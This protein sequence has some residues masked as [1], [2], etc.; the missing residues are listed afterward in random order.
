M[1]D[2]TPEGFEDAS[3]GG[4]RA[5]RADELRSLAQ[6]RIRNLPAGGTL[7]PTA[8]IHEAYLKLIAGG[9][10]GWDSPAHFFGAAARA[11]RNVAVDQARRRSRLKRGGAGQRLELDEALIPLRGQSE[12]EDVLALNDALIRLEALDERK[13]RIVTMRAFAELTNEQIAQCMGLSLSTIEREWRVA[14]AW[15][16]RELGSGSGALDSGD[17]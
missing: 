15:L 2:A 8:L 16:K 7:Q 3:S 17:A 6:V 13:S 12:P 11:M 5:L 14:R 10:P 4:R 9:D 1:G